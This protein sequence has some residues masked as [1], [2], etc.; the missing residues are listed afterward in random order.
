MDICT[1][2]NIKLKPRDSKRDDPN[3]IKLYVQTLYETTF[4]DLTIHI[5]LSKMTVKL[6]RNHGTVYS[7]YSD[8]FL[9]SPEIRR[10]LFEIGTQETLFH[11][12][13]LRREA[14]FRVTLIPIQ[15]LPLKSVLNTHAPS[16]YYWPQVRRTIFPFISLMPLGNFKWSHHVTF[17]C[18]LKIFHCY[19]LG[20]N[21]EESRQFEAHGQSE[22]PFLCHI[23]HEK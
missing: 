3:D 5:S 22:M 14:Y 21:T 8:A 6:L 12:S 2:N 23:A 4:R 1:R 19:P 20:T 10:K 17:L 13:L 11:I 16:I 7:I 18:T 9:R 15:A